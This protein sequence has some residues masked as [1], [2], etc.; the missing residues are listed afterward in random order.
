[1]VKIAVA[2]GKGGTG[3]TFVSTNL[4][5]TFLSRGVDIALTDCD[6]EEPNSAAFF[7]YE[8]TGGESVTQKVPVIDLSKCTY[9]GKCQDWCVYNAI[10]ILKERKIAK[11]LDEMCH[12]CGACTVACDYGAITEK[13]MVLGEVTKYSDNNRSS[14]IEGRLKVGVYTPVPVLKRAILSTTANVAVLDSP[15]GTSCPF[16]HTVN[17][18]DYVILVTE[19]TPFGLNDLKLSVEILNQMGKPFSV[20]I[21]RAGL[22]NRDV[23]NFLEREKIELLMEIPFDKEIASIYSKGGLVISEREDIA[24]KFS[25]IA[26]VIIDKTRAC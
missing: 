18:S 7:K 9:C 17:A 3:K 1:M 12:G 24:D 10:V 16:I 25:Y 5:Q 4:Y 22:G 2:S 13:D 19:P 11:V 20:I 21:N 26:D 23:H 14:I 15:P 6:A 8:E